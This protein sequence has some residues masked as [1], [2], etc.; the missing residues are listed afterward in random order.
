VRVARQ[1]EIGRERLA[2]EVVEVIG[3]QASFEE[4]ARVDSGRG[5]ALE[6]DLVATDPVAGTA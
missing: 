5:V 2:P 3:R 6:E 1:A 4:G